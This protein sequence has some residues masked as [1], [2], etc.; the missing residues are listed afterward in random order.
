VKCHCPTLSIE[1]VGWEGVPSR[2]IPEPEDLLQG[3]FSGFARTKPEKEG[4]ENQGAAP[5][6]QKRGRGFLF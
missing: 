2:A 6:F 5:S 4:E 3:S 1:R